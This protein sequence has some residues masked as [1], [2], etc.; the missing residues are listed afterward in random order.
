MSKGSSSRPSSISRKQFEENWDKIDW[1]P[2]VD[3]SKCKKKKK[4]VFEVDI[5]YLDDWRG[6]TK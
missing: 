2:H 4:S 6:V 1:G 5:P 3:M